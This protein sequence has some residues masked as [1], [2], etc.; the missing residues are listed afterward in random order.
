MAEIEGAVRG[1]L[2]LTFIPGLSNRGAELALIQAVR[3]DAA[4]RGRGVG[5]AFMAW[6]MDE[7]RRH[8]CATLELLTHHTRAD[9]RRFYER[10]GFEASHL[11]MKRPL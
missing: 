10:L 1:C 8:G 9:A 7:A 4:L 6:A 11:G 3:V 2:Q 5:R